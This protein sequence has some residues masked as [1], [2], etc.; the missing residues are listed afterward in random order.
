MQP[1]FITAYESLSQV[2][3]QRVY[4]ARGLVWSSLV[5]P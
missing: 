1:I 2:W 5:V 3:F 4:R